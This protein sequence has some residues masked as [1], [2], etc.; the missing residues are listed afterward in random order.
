MPA[1]A[2]RSFRSTG[3]RGYARRGGAGVDLNV[4]DWPQLN[5]RTASLWRSTGSHRVPLAARS[6]RVKSNRGHKMSR[7]ILLA[8]AVAAFAGPAFG[9]RAPSTPK[10]ESAALVHCLHLAATALA[11]VSSEPAET[12]VNATRGKCSDK[13]NDLIAAITRNAVPGASKIVD[14]T[15]AAMR[16]DLLATVLDIRTGVVAPRSLAPG[17]AAAGLDK[18]AE[19]AAFVREGSKVCPDA[20]Q[21]HV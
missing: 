19:M 14:G 18:I 6:N 10:V 13:E 7:I 11:I 15:I 20:D 21:W 3:G 1:P 9:Q 12:I 2:R 4:H 17:P 5:T 8:A 16:R